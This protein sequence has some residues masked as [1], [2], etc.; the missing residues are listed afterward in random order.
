MKKIVFS[1]A[2]GLSIMGGVQ[3]QSMKVTSAY[4]YKEQGDF[5]KAKEA[6]DEA[7]VHEKTMNDPKTH[8]YRGEIYI[9]LAI[10][11][12]PN[13][14]GLKDGAAETA[15]QA[16]EKAYELVDNNKRVSKSDIDKQ[17]S[18]LLNIY[19]NNAIAAY[20]GKDFVTAS[21]NFEKAANVRGHFG[22]LD[23]TAYY[24]AGAMAQQAE[25]FERAI[26]MYS[27][28]KETGY[29]S[30][31]LFYRIASLQLQLEN[32]DAAMETIQE[33]KA[34]FPGDKNLL[35]L[36]TNLYLKDPSKRDQA[37]TNLTEAIAG[38]PTNTTLLFARGTL[39]D[40]AGQKDLAEADYKKAVE[41]D[42]KNFDANYNLGAMYVNASG[43]V[44]EKM[45]NLDINDQKQYDILKKERDA[46]FNQ[47]I[48]PLETALSIE[49]D[50]KTVMKTL[51]ELYGKTGQSEK[52]S[53]MKTKVLGE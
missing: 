37:I 20:N 33:G 10:S 14:A 38:D 21:T 29:D 32:T 3:A 35:L 9:Q 12:N 6:I 36:E 44:Q 19:Y 41:I 4:N 2:I 17:Y 42:P 45:N 40:Q 26:E 18:Q 46:L 11:D 50:N 1:V 53:E 25:N 49:P 47:A 31:N 22:A 23:T 43:E 52:Y 51:M 27:K 16:L 39:Y 15:Q 8:L 13:Y 24:N 28:V 30:S 34:K 48:G 5:D 7:A